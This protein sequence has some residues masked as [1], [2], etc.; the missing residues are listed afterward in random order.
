MFF[1]TYF[2]LEGLTGEQTVCCPIPHHK[3]DGHTYMDTNPSCHINLDKRVWKCMSCGEHG[4]EVDMVAKVFNCTSAKASKFIT[5]LSRYNT[6]LDDLVQQQ[7]EDYTDEAMED[8]ESRGMNPEVLRCLNVCIE[9]V[10]DHFE[11]EFPISWEGWVCDIRRYR[12]GC[13]PK[14]VSES[15]SQSGMI[16]PFDVWKDEAPGRW[17]ILC[18]GEKDMVV[19]RG[20]GFNAITLSGGE[21]ATPLSPAWFKDRK[22][23]I[24]YDNDFTGRSGAARVAACIAPYTKELKIVESWKK[25]FN[26]DDTKEDLT[27][28]F[29]NYDGTAEKLKQAIHDTPAYE[30]GDENTEEELAPLVTLTEAIKSSNVGKIL[31]SQVQLLTTSEHKYEIPVKVKLKKLCDDKGK[32]KSGQVIRWSIE[33]ENQADVAFLLAGK[34]QERQKEIVKRA[35]GMAVEKGLGIYIEEYANLY[36]C[37][38]ADVVNTDMNGAESIMYFLGDDPSKYQKLMVTYLRVNN[39]ENGEVGML[40]SEW[41]EAQGDIESFQVT[42]SVKANLGFIQNHEGTIEDRILHRAEAVRGFLGYECNTN[43]ITA[44]D[45]CYNS[46]KEFNYGNQKR[47]KGFIDCLVIGESRVGKSD[48]AKR[49]QTAYNMG[50]FVSL[51]GSAATIPGIVG[52]SVQDAMGRRAT[53]AGVIPRNNGGLICFEELAKSERD[54]LKSLTDIRSSGLARITRVSGSLELPAALRMCTLTNVRPM[55]N[56]ETRPINA[57]SSG[58]E[59]VKDLIGTAE[60]IARYDYVYIQGDDGVESDPLYIAPEPYP[61]EA[62]RDAIKWTWSRKADQII[63]ADGTERLLSEKAKELNHTYPLHIK[64]YGTECW[65][66]LCRLAC[67]AAAYTISTDEQFENIIVTADH[68]EWAAKYMKNIYDNDTFKLRQLVEES[69]KDSQVNEKDTKI[70]QSKYIKYHDSLDYLN[71]MGRVDKGTFKDLSNLENNAMSA[72]VRALTMMHFITVDSTYIYSTTKF[73]ETYKL[74]DKQINV[75][76]I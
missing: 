59:I 12:P 39:P 68:V 23:A 25:D 16:L 52:G 60:D 20:M 21:M 54:I 47:V 31:R 32:M 40:A 26:G 18:A 45:M 24:C 3:A 11:Y 73:R 74:L 10:D 75:E 43:L 22:V 51:A 41:T 42:E 71:T 29:T 7:W 48:T 19:T 44:I 62:L 56:G 49:L 27:D 37:Q 4:T 13:I 57:Y 65:K 64:L 15:G 34:S 66:K 46:V 28:W 33:D 2:N 6:K 9:K 63:W 53:R 38:V 14:V 1:E 70:L 61:I 55:G 8:A 5:N 36:A 17:T 76:E 72:V 30:V 50:A 67:A 69:L 58:V 35:A